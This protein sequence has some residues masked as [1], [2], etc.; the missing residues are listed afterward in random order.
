MSGFNRL[1]KLKDHLNRKHPEV[2]VERWYKVDNHLERRR[3]TGLME[4]WLLSHLIP[5]GYREVSKRGEHEV[6]MRSKGFGPS[7]YHPQAFVFDA[8]D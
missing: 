6:Q 1:D 7:H 3:R 5:G 2:E 4:R 8:E